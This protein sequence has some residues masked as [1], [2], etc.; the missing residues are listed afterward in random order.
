VTAPSR[1]TAPLATS[2]PARAVPRPGAA[3]VRR[4]GPAP[5]RS[6]APQ[7]RKPRE[8]SPLVIIVPVVAVAVAVGLMFLT[9]V[10]HPG[11]SDQT[12]AATGMSWTIPPGNYEKITVNSSKSFWISGSVTGTAPMDS[13]LLDA[14]QLHKFNLQGNPGSSY[15]ASGTVLSTSWDVN[16]ASGTYY[17]VFVSNVPTSALTVQVTQSIVITS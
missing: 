5:P 15:W 14:A 16:V 17:L 7:A 4:P 1:P 11:A 2:P 9:S 8:F 12:V 10:L 3:P 13:W 6:A